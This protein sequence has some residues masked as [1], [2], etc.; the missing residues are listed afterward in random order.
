M[1]NIAWDKAKNEE[2]IKAMLD[3]IFEVHAEAGHEVELK[4]DRDTVVCTCGLDVTLLLVYD[5]IFGY[6]IEAIVQNDGRGRP[7]W[8]QDLEN[9]RGIVYGTHPK[10]GVQ[11][12]AEQTEAGRCCPECGQPV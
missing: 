1:A 10:Y 3:K 12:K 2:G 11:G 9:L 7:D 4:A 6:R 8:Y 5:N